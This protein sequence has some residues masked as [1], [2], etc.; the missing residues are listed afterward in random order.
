MGCSPNV[1]LLFQVKKFIGVSSNSASQRQF[2][3][4]LFTFGALMFDF[5]AVSFLCSRSAKYSNSFILINSSSLATTFS[6][7]KLTTKESKKWKRP[8]ELKMKTVLRRMTTFVSFSHDKWWQI[9]P[10]KDQNFF[11][12]I[13]AS[14][15][16]KMMK[17]RLNFLFCCHNVSI[18]LTRLGTTKINFSPLLFSVGRWLL[19]KCCK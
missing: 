5:I 1:K 4:S 19:W 13:C 8:T 7:R 9:C 2:E 12:L 16:T 10:K 15:A 6:E 17:K 11:R 18:K 3:T 14:G